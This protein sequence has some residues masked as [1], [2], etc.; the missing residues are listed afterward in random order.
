MIAQEGDVVDPGIELVA[1]KSRL[2][3]H[4]HPFRAD[5]D[6]NGVADPAGRHPEGGDDPAAGLHPAEVAFDPD[7]S[8]TQQVV[9][10]DKAGHELPLRL[11]I[12]RFGRRHLLDSAPLEDGHPIRHGH[13]LLLVVGDVDDGHSQLPL[14]ASHLVLHL[15]PQ[16][17]V[18]GSQGFVHQHQ[19]R[20]EHQRPGDGHPLLL[21]AGKLARPPA[22]Q[23][24][25]AHQFQR[26]ADAFPNLDR[27][28]P[29]H[30]QG[31]GE[32]FPDG[33]VGKQGIVLE[34][35]ADVAF[36]R[37][38]IV[39]GAPADA[40]AARGGYLKAGQ[41][42]QAGGLSGAGRAEQRQELALV[43]YQV[44]VPN[45]DSPTVVALADPFELDVCLSGRLHRRSPSVF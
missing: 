8:S 15:L 24:F 9:V 45:H 3:G 22:F 44:Q 6:R 20:L 39:Y 41:H 4:G 7:D 26:A 25:Q 35:D 1:I 23:P 43:N 27:V 16:A 36:T 31:K 21:P 13:G 42:H 38:E 14:N 12:E 28:H 30:F 34:D 2:R 29:P 32:V 5:G 19:G 37:G 40:D 11:F 17:A 33:H 10:S 18:Q